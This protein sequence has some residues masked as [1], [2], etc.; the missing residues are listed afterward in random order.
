MVNLKPSTITT[1]RNFKFI[2]I[3][4]WI[5][6]G[7]L[8][9]G[10]IIKKQFAAVA[11]KN[12]DTGTHIIH[13]LTDFIINYWQA[14][15][16]NTQRKHALNTVKFLNYLLFNKRS[17]DIRSLS[18]L[19]FS[20]GNNYLNTL[21]SEGQSRGSVKD[22]E[23]TLTYFYLWLI[24]KGVSNLDRNRFIKKVTQQG[25]SYYESPFQVVYPEHRPSNVEH[26]FPI[27]YIP[28]L[29]EIAILVAR[30]I[31][32]GVYIQLFGGLRVGEVV[33]LK[34][35]QLKRRIANGDF[36]F[37]IKDQNFRTDLKD[38]SGSSNVKRSRKQRVF[39]I[40][41]WG[42]SLFNDHIELFAAAD[43][44]NALFVN[45][46]GK[47]MSGRSYR[48]YFDKLKR[49]FIEYLKTYGDSDDKLIAHHLS[50]M[51]WSTHIGRG[52]FTNMLAEIAENPYDIAFPRGD[53]SLLSSLSYMSRTERMRKKLEEK[54]NNMHGTYIPRLIEKRNSQKEH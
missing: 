5:D 23:R 14:K 26:A 39:Q 33:N 8:S 37:D 47:A 48:Q 54:F 35:T 40:R 50:M 36:L 34:R 41:D 29:I 31:A 24:G 32:L 11:L 7:T 13:P 30:P 6:W 9:D 10:K 19:N 43:K 3:S 28:L 27:R 21:T 45:R 15:K 1:L 51:S 42:E 52:T 44:S 17:M 22:S 2:M 18:D 12:L 25:K 49:C 38:S 16:F 53:K 4:V 20:D 46:D